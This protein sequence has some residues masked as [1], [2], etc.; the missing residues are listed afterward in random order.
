MSADGN[1]AGEDAG[2]AHTYSL[3]GSRGPGSR[4]GP[5]GAITGLSGG[6]RIGGGG[7]SPGGMGMGGS[8]SLRIRNG[9]ARFIALL[10][11]RVI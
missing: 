3:C 2:S 9:L 1:P 10:H 7:S 5:S 11:D 4:I 6:S 8:S